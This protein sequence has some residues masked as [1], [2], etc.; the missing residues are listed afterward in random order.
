MTADGAKALAPSGAEVAPAGLSELAPLVL[1]RPSTSLLSAVEARVLADP[2]TFAYLRQ[3]TRD[4]NAAPVASGATKPTSAYSIE[5]VEDR[6][7]VVAHLS[8]PVDKYWLQDVGELRTFVTDEL[9]YGLDVAVE[10]QMLAGDGVGENMRGMQVQ[11]WSADGLETLRKAITKL[12]VVGVESAVVA[13]HPADWE[14][15]SL[16][17]TT[18]NAFL[19][20]EAVMTTDAR[21]ATSPA[22][23]A[24]RA[25][26]LGRPGH[27]ERRRRRRA[28]RRVRPEGG[29]ALH[30]R[31]GQRRVGHR[32]RVRQE[33]DHRPVRGPLRRRRQAARPD[34]RC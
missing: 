14:T 23:R 7:R 6:L 22:V 15:L 29:H 17:R 28:G 1:T 20:T 31:A 10:Q 33:P 12:Q 19:A 25:R 4:N 16:I 32:H 24:D 2:P 18:T 3:T 13:M 30:R 9:A 34:R 26:Q 8:E 5:R 11:A 21:G 27:P